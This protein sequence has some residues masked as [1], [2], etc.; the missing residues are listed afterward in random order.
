MQE[1]IDKYEFS[2]AISKLKVLVLDSDQRKEAYILLLKLLEENS[3]IEYC[4][5]EKK[6][7]SFLKSSFLYEDM[8]RFCELKS[9]LNNSLSINFKIFKLESLWQIGKIKAFVDYARI[10]NSEILDNKYF[11]VYDE[12]YKIVTSRTTKQL[13][14]KVGKLIFLLETGNIKS[15]TEHILEFKNSILNSKREFSSDEKKFIKS[16]FNILLMYKDLS[17]IVYY[18]HLFYNYLNYVT[19][20]K[21]GEIP[22]KEIIEYILLNKEKRELFILLEL[23]LGIL[24]YD[25]VFEYLKTFQRKSIPFH[26]KKCRSAFQNDVSMARINNDLTTKRDELESPDSYVA[27][28]IL[29]SKRVDELFIHSKVEISKLEKNLITQFNIEPPSVEDL[30]NLVISFIE[31]GMNHIALNLAERMENSS[32]KSYLIAQINYNICDYSEAIYYT[33]NAIN[34]F[35]MGLDDSVPFLYIKARSFEALGKTKEAQAAYRKIASSDPDFM[36]IRSKL[37]F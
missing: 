37:V 25:A 11:H 6:Y 35:S 2:E 16:I 22:A 27:T 33:N 34:E 7:I 24:A 28:K 14:M 3:C 20:E 5:Y 18:D 32:N 26:F 15:Y 10:L 12:F 13:F 19:E 23:D 36:N 17:P 21:T 30:S 31:M 9:E 4:E 1:H 29:S 8:C